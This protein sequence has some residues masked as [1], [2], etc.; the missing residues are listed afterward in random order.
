[1]IT[2]DLSNDEKWFR[3]SFP[4]NRATVDLVKKI[5]GRKWNPDSKIWLVP[6]WPESIAE[7]KKLSIKPMPAAE[8]ILSAGDRPKS[9]VQSLPC[10]DIV[11]DKSRPLWRHQI[12]MITWAAN[13]KRALWHCGMGTGKTRAAVD[14]IQTI[15]DIKRV[16]VACPL[17][18]IPAWDKQV[19]MFAVTPMRCVCLDSGSVDKKMKLAQKTLEITGAT[20]E[21]AVLV[22]NYE[23]LW[24]EPF[25]AWAL[26]QRFDL[27]VFD[28]AQALK[29]GGGK[30]SRYCHKLSGTAGRVLGLSGTPLPHSPLDAYGVFRALDDSIFGT[31]FT[32]FRMRYAV[33]GGFQNKQVTGYINQDEMSRK[34]DSIRI[35]VGREV[36]DLPPAVHTEMTFALDAKTEAVYRELE[37]ELYV[38]VASGEVTAANALTRLL[39]LQ[40]ITSGYLPLDEVDGDENKNRRY[41]H[42]NNGKVDQLRT[43]LDGLPVDEPVVVFCRFRN[44]LEA[45]HELCKDMGRTSSEISGSRKELAAWQAGESSVLAAQ[46]RTAREGVDMVRACYC[47]YFSIGFSLGDYEQSLARTHR[48]GQDRTVFYYHLIAENTVDRKVYNAL[49]D[50]KEVVTAVLGG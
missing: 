36:L 50:K 29:S 42:L 45:A 32:R 16:L 28:E 21:V 22:I 8:A 23:S 49:K 12:N 13:N 11:S 20:K 6:V 46:I 30:A 5:P 4:Y 47:V 3:L 25:G 7:L 2:V 9:E 37:N 31:S 10:P 38:R 18:V 14:F 19:G 40:Q 41:E 39:R 26:K 43:I 48:P 27:V 1:M 33:M 24:R 17:A 44:D 15:P 35:H 34:I